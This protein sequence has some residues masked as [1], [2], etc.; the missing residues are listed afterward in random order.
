MF[1]KDGI[2]FNIY[3]SQTIDEITYGD[4]T[5]PELRLALGIEEISEPAQPVDYSES[6]YY[7]TELNEAPYVVYTMKSNEQLA[8][9]Y[10]DELRKQKDIIN[11]QR[12]AD[13]IAGVTHDGHL[14]H[15]DD[16]FLIEL[17]GMILGYQAGIFTGTQ[18]VRTKEN[19]IESLN[20]AQIMALASAVGDH[21]KSVY[22]AS[23]AIKD[24]LDAEPNPYETP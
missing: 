17:L 10:D 7:R 22:A 3:A 23:W 1:I 20:L 8:A 14:W 12:D 11:A 5:S 6:L 15:C 16:R 24:E 2:R 4:F 19:T 9:Q 21:R 18:L 13:I